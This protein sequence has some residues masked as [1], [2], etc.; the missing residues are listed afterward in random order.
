MPNITPL[1]THSFASHVIRSLLVSLLPNLVCSEDTVRSRK[2][3]TWKAR[4]GEFKSFF[5]GRK[6]AE[7]LLSKD[8]VAEFGAISRRIIEAIRKDLDDNEIRVMASDKV[9]CPMLK[10][11]NPYS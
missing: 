5:N 4:Q 2:S 7:C 3:A 8:A 11:R 10:V 6:K 1:I 9:A